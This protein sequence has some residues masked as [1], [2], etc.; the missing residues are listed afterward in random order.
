MGPAQVVSH[1]GMSMMNSSGPM[2][3]PGFLLDHQ[4]LISMLIFFHGFID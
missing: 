1:Q 3:Q 2:Q 4:F